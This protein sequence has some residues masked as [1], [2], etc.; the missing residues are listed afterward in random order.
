MVGSRTH[1][2]GACPPPHDRAPAFTATFTVG[3]LPAE[4]GYRWVTAD[5]SVSDPGWRTLSFPSGGE[6]SRQDGVVVT[7]HDDT[8]AF[9]SAVRVEVRSPVRAT[10]DAVAFSV[11]CGTGTETETGTGTPAGRGLP[12]LV[13]SAPSSSPSA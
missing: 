9:E 3:R 2:S 13:S 12:L 4:V 10:S 8:G 1:Y 5:G 11:T 7:T 6:R